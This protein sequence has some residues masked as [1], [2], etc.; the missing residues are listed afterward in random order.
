VESLSSYAR[1]FLGQMD[2]P[3]VDFIEGLSPAV[4]IDQKSTNRNPRSTVGT[5][6]EVH[7][8]LRLLYARAGVPHCPV[9][10]HVIEKQTP[11]Q[12]V[13]QVLAMP[14]GSRFQVL[15]PVVRTRKGEFVDLFATLQTQGYSRVLV[16]GTVHQL[17]APPTLKKQEKHDISVI[18][19]RLAVKANA[20][21]RLTDSV[22][23]ALRLAD[24]LVVL[25][26]GQLVAGDEHGD[27]ML[28]RQR[29]QSFL[30]LQQF[31]G[32]QTHGL[33]EL[34]TPVLELVLRF[35]DVGDVKAGSDIAN[36]L[37]IVRQARSAD[38]P[39]PSILAIG[40]LKTEL[41]IKRSTVPHGFRV[42]RHVGL[43][44]FVVDV[45]GP[46]IVRHLV[47]LPGPDEF[48]IGT[49]DE[50][51]TVQAIHPNQHGRAVGNRP[52]SHLALAQSRFRAFCCTNIRH[53]HDEARDVSAGVPMRRVH[54][55]D[56]S[57]A[58]MPVL[59]FGFIINRL[60]L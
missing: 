7:D 3:D 39:H 34:L 47:L 2:K 19:D 32:L 12:I 60:P 43:P 8:Y 48:H 26:L 1:Q 6:T 56:P 53:H 51:T 30:G 36:Q 37:C 50:F 54:R 9:C 13:D 27:S 49:V 52:K 58:A 22:E 42:Q 5:I 59:G 16:D 10:G 57:G 28:R 46:V 31:A 45:P 44:V 55:V 25:D 24:G 15:A 40:P 38:R 17:S 14:E 18:V 29:A 11:Q 35:T 20:K 41:G 21:Q 33:F 23:T 4:S